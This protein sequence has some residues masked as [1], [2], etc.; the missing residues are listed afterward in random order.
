M[1]GPDDY[2]QQFV[3]RQMKGLAASVDPDFVINAGDNFYPGSITKKC[4]SSADGPSDPTGQFG[5]VYYSMYSGPGLDGKPWLSVMGNH[6][7]GGRSY[8]EGWDVQIFHTW[9]SDTWVMPAQ[10][11]TQ[12]VQYDGFSVEVFML[13]SNFMDAFSK[14]ADPHHNICQ[15]WYHTNADC[16]GITHANCAKHF[17]SSWKASLDMLEVS[18]AASTAE[19]KIILTHFPGPSIAGQREI[20]NLN[21]KYGIDLI[22][23]GHTHY[24]SHGEDHGIPWIIS[25]GGG[26]VTSDSKPRLDGHDMSYGFVDFTVTRDTLKYDM[27]SWGGM[28]NDGSEQIIMAT[29]TFQKNGGSEMSAG[30]AVFV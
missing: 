3:A 24:Q 12:L 7:Y 6:D 26:G 2:G 18:L 5:N 30:Q 23:T 14:D 15:D 11:W 16:W 22:F 19:W 27:V 8:E 4:P 9:H 25:G 13:D 17:Q 21:S 28:D 20:Q 1:P 10:Y 29:K